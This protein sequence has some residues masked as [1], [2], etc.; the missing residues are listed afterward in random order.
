M[1]VRPAKSCRL[2][3][4]MC[5]SG[6]VLY[7]EIRAEIIIRSGRPRHRGSARRWQLQLLITDPTIVVDSRPARE[8]QNKSSWSLASTT[9]SYRL[10]S[11]CTNVIIIGSVLR[12]L[13][14][15]S[16]IFP[17]VYGMTTSNYARGPLLIKFWQAGSYEEL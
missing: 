13:V 16:I 12:A 3:C 4:D 17:G 7:T 2:A 5:M 9:V 8:S 14:R 11:V 6:L 10:L 15:V 1:F